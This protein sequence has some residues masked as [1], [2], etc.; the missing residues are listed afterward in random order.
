MLKQCKKEYKRRGS[1]LTHT[2]WRP[3]EVRKYMTARYAT[4]TKDMDVGPFASELP[5]S[6][7]EGFPA[8]MPKFVKDYYDKLDQDCA[9]VAALM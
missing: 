5:E 1:P 2:A 3:A 6:T 8:E 4:M 9:H 7:K